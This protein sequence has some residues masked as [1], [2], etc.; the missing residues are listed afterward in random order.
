M[1]TG[2]CPAGSFMCGSDSS[3]EVDSNK[4]DRI[5]GRCVRSDGVFSFENTY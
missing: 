3:S 5:L 4:F 2:L 1:L